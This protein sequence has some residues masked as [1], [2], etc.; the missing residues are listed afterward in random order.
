MN[1]EVAQRAKEIA[2]R[3]LNNS[4]LSSLPLLRKEEEIVTFVVKNRVS[5]EQVL[6]KEP[7]FAG[8][9][10][11]E[12]EKAVLDAVQQ[13]A[14]DE[15]S[16]LVNDIFSMP[17]I[18]FTEFSGL[19]G[20]MTGDELTFRDDFRE[21]FLQL[22]ASRP[23]RRF[24]SGVLYGLRYGVIQRYMSYGVFNR[25]GRLYTEL[26]RVDK[27]PVSTPPALSG[28]I[29]VLLLL[30]A[31]MMIRIPIMIGSNK[32][33]LNYLDALEV[34]ADKNAYIDT[35]INLMKKKVKKFPAGI[36]K[37][38][39]DSFKDQNEV[40]ELSGTGK[41]LSVMYERLL[42]YNPYVKVH[43]GA[44]TPDKSWFNSARRNYKYYGFDIALL[45]E[46]YLIASENEW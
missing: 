17:D 27:L 7:A 2:H 24:A 5:L 45:D 10:Y 31:F 18:D 11:E 30:K 3:F 25:K 21:L 26:I 6:K 22:V 15:A 19:I 39:E 43:R 4:N 8:M 42:D 9:S 34:K 28:Y 32:H 12:I 13:V 44:E 35:F 38:L 23:F 20:V 14:I 37:P 29:G 40:K 36:V 46:F 1:P 33:F 16:R 41:V